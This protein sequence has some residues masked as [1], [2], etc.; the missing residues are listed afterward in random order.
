MYKPI[1]LH[2][3]NNII[4]D[5]FIND[6]NYLIIIM[7]YSGKP[8]SIQYIDD[9]IISFTLK[10][11]SHQ[12]TYIY[13]SDRKIK[14]KKRI[15][16]KLNENKIETRVNKYPEFKDEIIMSTMVKN[17]DNY[18]RQW[19]DFHLHIGVKHFI[20]YDNSETNDNKS[21][22]S[23][24][25]T[26]NLESILADYIKNKLVLLIKWP[27]PKRVNISGISGQTTQQN[28]SIYAFQNSK[29]IGLFDIDEYVNIQNNSTNIYNFF[30]NLIK[31]ENIDIDNIGSFRLLNKNFYNPY[32]LPTIGYEF[33]KIYNCDKNVTLCTEP[34][35]SCREKCFVIPKNVDIY[36][37]HMIV[38]GKPMYD[39]DSSKIYFNHYTYLNKEGRG[40]NKTN[41][42]DYSISRHTSN[43]FDIN[44]KYFYIKSQH[45]TYLRADPD[46]TVN[47]TTKLLEWERW[48]LEREDDYF[49]IKSSHGT[50]LRG[51]LDRTVNLTT[52]RQ[53]WERWTIKQ[54]NGYLCKSRF[55]GTYL[56]ADPGKTVNLTT[57][58]L[59]WENWQFILS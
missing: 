20:I 41:F 53:E 43:H 32:N 22:Q 17:E 28:H 48:S 34:V 44:K 30:T 11:C 46:K 37:V 47:L 52:N 3:H 5:I 12:H 7:P 15:T 2:I 23:V 49:Y 57:K 8:P 58:P 9:S 55:H 29:Y 6:N 51:D 10:I 13:I 35:L 54:D 4:Y 39:V 40:R 59:E 45:G 14:H 36:S 16:L 27:Y 25:K 50:Y 21:Y 42:M 38:S 18:I 26:S 56:R 19:I 33:L 1:T 31:E 24:E